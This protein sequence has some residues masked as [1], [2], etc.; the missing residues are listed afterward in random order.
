MLP[1]RS[2]SVT[3]LRS[4]PC[5]AVTGYSLM[6]SRVTCFGLRSR[7][8]RGASFPFLRGLP[9]WVDGWGCAC[10]GCRFALSAPT[11]G[12]HSVIPC[13]LPPAFGPSRE[14][15]IH[16][17]GA[18]YCESPPSLAFPP[19][20]PQ[21]VCPPVCC[22]PL[23]RTASSREPVCLLGSPSSCSQLLV[24][25]VRTASSLVSQADN[26]EQREQMSTLLPSPCG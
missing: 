24:P 21:L 14:D 6:V 16:L 11:L 22:A 19:A 1:A 17:G 25:P 5:P 13:C 8:Q 23:P 18:S 15:C 10:S 4:H 7:L 2:S 3:L 26:H 12:L 20:C 9:T